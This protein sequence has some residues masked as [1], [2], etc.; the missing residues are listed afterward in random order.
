MS[1]FFQEI[2]DACVLL[3]IRGIYQGATLHRRGEALYASYKNGYVKLHPS[4][5]TSNS[6]VYWRDISVPYGTVVTKGIDLVWDTDTAQAA[7]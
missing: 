4:Q 5:N 3:S 1:P 6:S 7:E 2:A